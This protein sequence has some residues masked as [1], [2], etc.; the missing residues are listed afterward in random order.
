MDIRHIAVFYS[1]D[2][3]RTSLL[4]VN[5]IVMSKLTAKDTTPTP[6]GKEC[7]GS[8]K[9][10]FGDFATTREAYPTQRDDKEVTD[11]L[12]KGNVSSLGDIMTPV[13]HSVVAPLRAGAQ[14]EH[15]GGDL[16][17]HEFDIVL[18]PASQIHMSQ[19]EELPSP[20]R[21]QIM[22]KLEKNADEK[23]GASDIEPQLVG[24]TRFRQTDMRRMMKLAAVKSGE[25]VLSS[26]FGEPVSLTQLDSLPLEM[27]L[28]VAND[29]DRPI[30]FL[31]QKRRSA[32]SGDVR[33]ERPPR[34]KRRSRGKRKQS[35]ALP[36]EMLSL[37]SSKE[38]MPGSFY[39][40]NVKPLAIF[41]DENDSSDSEAFG[42]V[43]QFLEVCMNESRISDIVILLRSIH[44]RNDDWCGNAFD[45]IFDAVNSKTKTLLGHCL[46]K[47]W[48]MST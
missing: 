36:G 2:L 39:V 23:S 40:D 19:V 8:I 26:A 1:L 46:D 13:S 9:N 45:E 28:Q 38:S 17:I 42:N 6:R 34:E 32:V 4:C 37:S 30:G 15:E 44:N 47:E 48:I 10:L 43:V 18:P 33:T 29:D 16:D 24:D 11:A 35:F 5:S 7:Y 21:R 3:T 41:L 14:T 31:S 20:L 25:H 22:S 12:R 27:Q